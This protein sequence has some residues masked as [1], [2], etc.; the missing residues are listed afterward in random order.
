MYGIVQQT[1]WNVNQ[2][3]FHLKNEENLYS[4]LH[5]LHAC[6]QLSRQSYPVFLDEQRIRAQDRGSRQTVD[7]CFVWYILSYLLIF[8]KIPHDEVVVLIPAGRRH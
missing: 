3:A 8:I 4:F 1:T 2:R 6:V 5:N 7:I